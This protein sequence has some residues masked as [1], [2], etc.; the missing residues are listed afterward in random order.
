MKTIDDAKDVADLIL[1]L[2]PNHCEA[3]G[4][5]GSVARNG[6]G[7]DIDLIIFATFTSFETQFL[8]LALAIIGQVEKP[9]A[10]D[11]KNA[12]HRAIRQVFG[13]I[14]TE[15]LGAGDLFDDDVDA[16][17]R[18]W[19]HSL[20]AAVENI[21]QVGKTNAMDAEIVCDLRIYVPQE[22][23]FVPVA[24]LLIPSLTNPSTLFQY[25]II[26]Q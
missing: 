14:A 26:A 11:K 12:R 23:Q 19:S 22:K 20:Q 17:V 2:F 9:T 16:F 7:N 13:P 3:V 4:L 8:D 18:R 25:P 21:R 5:F 10:V 24:D 15:P 6:Q 1:R